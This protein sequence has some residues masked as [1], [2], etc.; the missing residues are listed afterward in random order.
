MTRPRAALV[1]AA[2]FVAAVVLA[3]WLTA[4]YHFVPVGFGLE[5]TAGT[6]AAGACLALRDGLQDAAGRW[7]VA[8]AIGAGAALSWATST[9]ALALASG[10]AFLVSEALDAAVYTPL[11]GRARTGGPRW[12]GAVTASNVAGAV[13]DTLAFLT[14]AFGTA[15]VTW[16]ALGGQ[17]VGKAWPTL[18]FL[19]A[20]ALL[21]WVVSRRRAVPREPVYAAG[22]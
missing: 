21:G 12:A 3:N 20:G 7:A 4:R 13:V 14:L 19:G 17:L 5:A 18:A 10:A 8:L 1:L 2:A 16:A 9:P 22:A 15:A 6:F 11:R